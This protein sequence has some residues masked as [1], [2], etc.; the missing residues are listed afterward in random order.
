MNTLNCLWKLLACL[1]PMK[2]VYL[3]FGAHMITYWCL[4][5]KSW[6]SFL[7]FLLFISLI[8]LRVHNTSFWK[9]EDPSEL[10]IYKFSIRLIWFWKN[11]HGFM[12]YNLFD[13]SNFFFLCLNA[14]WFELFYQIDPQN[15]PW[16]WLYSMESK[17]LSQSL[18]SVHVC[19][20]N[21]PIERG[22][23]MTWVTKYWLWALI[24]LRNSKTST[25]NI[26]LNY[27]FNLKFKQFTR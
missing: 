26:M 23:L 20:N 4:N 24:K 25:S 19:V 22:K 13:L 11:A 3:F 12:L 16:S 7:K 9:F 1:Y 17:Y 6:T 5:I 18:M 8:L 27:Q 2:P 10:L 14:H 21:G 15:S